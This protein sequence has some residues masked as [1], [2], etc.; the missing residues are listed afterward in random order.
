MNMMEG[1]G[2]G[3]FLNMQ[4]QDIK[5]FLDHKDLIVKHITTQICVNRPLLEQLMLNVS[6]ISGYISWLRFCI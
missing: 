2:D 3:S 1:G 4:Y 5:Y 6:F